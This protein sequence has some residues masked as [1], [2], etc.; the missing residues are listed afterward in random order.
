M[1]RLICPAS[2]KSNRTDSIL[3]QNMYLIDFTHIFAASRKFLKR[4]PHYLSS[5]VINCCHLS[6]VIGLH[7][8]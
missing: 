8:V 7:F 2:Y 6:P 5:D 1:F 3:D 4:L